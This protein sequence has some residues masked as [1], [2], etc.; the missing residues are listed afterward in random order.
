MSQAKLMMV[1]WEHDGNVHRVFH[2]SANGVDYLYESDFN[3]CE[4]TGAAYWHRSGGGPGPTIFLPAKVC[5]DV[6][7]RIWADP[8]ITFTRWENGET[9]SIERGDLP[10]I[11]YAVD[12]RHSRRPDDPCL[13]E[14]ESDGYWCKTCPGDGDGHGDWM[15]YDHPCEHDQPEKD[16]TGARFETK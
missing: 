9:V 13:E 10:S 16:P 11:G 14:I 15:P 2:S 8:K 5:A 1:E 4:R 3:W 7:S 6:P 12:P